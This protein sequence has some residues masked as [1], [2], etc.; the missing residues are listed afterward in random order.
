GP[1]RHRRAPASSC[2]PKRGASRLCAGRHDPRPLPAC[3]CR[4]SGTPHTAGAWPGRL[5]AP[6]ATGCR[7]LGRGRSRAA[8]H[9]LAGRWRSGVWWVAGRDPG[10]APHAHS[11][12]RDT[13]A[14]GPPASATPPF[15]RL[16]GTGGTV[17]GGVGGLGPAGCLE[18]LGAVVQVAGGLGEGVGFT[19]E[20]QLE[21]GDDLVQ[22]D[23]GRCGRSRRGGG[24][25]Q[26]GENT[27][28]HAGYYY[29][30]CFVLRQDTRCRDTLPY[31][32][33]RRQHAVGL[34]PRVP[35]RRPDAVARTPVMRPPVTPG[36]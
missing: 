4:A 31:V 28:E 36:A 15:C 10:R 23:V 5:D 32:P 18:D 20:C 6:S 1:F 27:G 7:S 11:P 12:S 3:R 26:A 29:T 24:R 9:R 33:G 2:Y 30:L 16:S 34:V 25:P 17:A 35:V 19:A 13:R 21:R 8:G 22:G 14:S